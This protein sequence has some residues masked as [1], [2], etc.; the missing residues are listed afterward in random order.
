MVSFTTS[1]PLQD[2]VAQI[3][4][5]TPLGSVLKSRE[6]ELVP[7]ELRMRAMF[8]AQVENER[9]LAEAQTR[10]LQ[11]IKLE[12]TVLA[13]GA[14]GAL[15]DR[16]R[17]IEEM[18]Q[19]LRDEGYKRGP[20]K[21]GSLLDLKSTRRLGLIW[22]MNLAQAQGYAR[23]KSDQTAIGLEN[24]PAYELVRLTPRI[25]IRDWP[26]IWQEHGGKFTG[27]P[28]KDYP[29][30]PGRMI[31]L[32]TDP[33]WR[34]ISRFKTPWPPFDW[35]SGMGLTGI[36]RSDAE[37]LGIIAPDDVLTPLSKPFNDGYQMSLSGVPESGRE[38]LRSQFGSS[39]LI[40]G[41]T[42]S[43]HNNTSPARDDTASQIP[44]P[45]ISERARAI[46]DAGRDQ[47]MG[48]R[49]G[50]D[51]AYWP[52][53]FAGG[54]YDAEL[55]ASTSAVAVGRK[56]LYH[57][58]W[59]GYAELF[60][61]LIRTW[62]PESV[63]VTVLDG[64][65]HAWRPDLLDLTPEAIQALSVAHENGVLL[66][67]G[68]DMFVDPFAMVRILDAQGN[69]LGGFQAPAATAQVYAEA[70]AKDFVD[71]LGIVVRVLINGEEVAL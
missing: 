59:A 53:G 57:E 30:A 50:D 39:I 20:A 46:A 34:Y 47:I 65:V 31:A 45:S 11:R 60:A 67:Y 15:M 51:A 49:S 36:D 56:L 52:P 42:I 41:D 37:D 64:H 16:G 7:A 8:S 14:D 66:G 27:R 12:R 23:W 9:V 3:S 22:D 38:R 70:R 68:Q 21:K 24:E 5:R 26:L 1:A 44:K 18:R 55:L 32:K 6:W 29:S 48:L 4:G 35:D 69:L 62:L 58:E 2:A 19:V 17:F 71:A 13:D 43:I 54:D 40:D 28:G 33:I 10:L 63:E 61:R 25:E